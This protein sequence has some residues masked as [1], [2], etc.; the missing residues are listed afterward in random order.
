MELEV[1]DLS[2]DR[3][4]APS[5]WAPEKDPFTPVPISISSP[6]GGT[7]VIIPSGGRNRSQNVDQ[8]VDGTEVRKYGVSVLAYRHSPPALIRLEFDE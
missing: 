3:S 2:S 6:S 8:S 4:S 1:Q 7:A 5:S